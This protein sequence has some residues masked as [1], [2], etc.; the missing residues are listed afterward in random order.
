MIRP[1]LI[2]FGLLLM[3]TQYYFDAITVNGQFFIFIG[4]I[5]LLGIPHGAA[6]L[7][8]ANSAAN[9]AR[10]Q[11]SIYRF[12]FNYLGRL[13]LF[14]LTLWL[15]PLIGNLLFMAFAAYHFGETDLHRFNTGTF[16]GKAF[17]TS[18]GFIILGCIL[19]NHFADVK[20]LLLM[21]P[22]GVAH[23]QFI[24]AIGNYRYTIML[25]TIILFIG[26]ATLYFYQNHLKINNH[27][28]LF[29]QLL[30][31]SVILFNLP[32]VLG[33]S[34]Y[35]VLWHSV[36]SIRSIVKYL[37]R[38]TSISYLKIIGKMAGYSLLAIAGIAAFGVLGFMYA[39]RSAMIVY[40]F[41]GLAVLT[42]P[43]MQIMHRMYSNIRLRESN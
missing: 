4:G 13:G 41:L 22:S 19:L 33:F 38:D 23:L 30:V 3:L 15:F 6:D 7:L 11:F 9:D 8:I 21:F 39:N 31:I 25:L 2:A 12:L 29:A 1:L 43:H 35:F 40:V 20:S 36:F 10:T 26:S 34:F 42:A 24:N 32:M 16:A 5:I 14:G 18:Y 27:L 37:R 17:V 28:L